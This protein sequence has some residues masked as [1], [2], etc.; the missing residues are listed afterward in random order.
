VLLKLFTY[1]SPTKHTLGLFLSF[2][3][4]TVRG[5]RADSLWP[6]PQTVCQLIPDSPG[7]SACADSSV[8]SRAYF[9]E[10]LFCCASWSSPV[11]SWTYRSC[12]RLLLGFDFG[13]TVKYFERNLRLP[14]TFPLVVIFGPS[15]LVKVVSRKAKTTDIYDKGSMALFRSQSRH[16]KHCADLLYIFCF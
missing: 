16:Q 7:L 1:F 6:Q 2:S 10:R 14:F 9:R 3:L 12:M 8:S 11:G 13:T 15:Y 5:L 4:W